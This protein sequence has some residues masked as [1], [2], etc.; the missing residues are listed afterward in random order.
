MSLVK[1]YYLLKRYK[2]ECYS[3]TLTAFTSL[4]FNRISEA[5]GSIT[6]AEA[7]ENIIALDFCG[8][9]MWLS[10]IILL[11]YGLILLLLER[12][13][14][15]RKLS[16]SFFEIMKCYVGESIRDSLSNGVLAWGEGKTV[17]YADN[18]ING[19]KSKNIICFYNDV[20]YTFLK[21][22]DREKRYGQ[23]PYYFNN[24]DWEAFENTEAFKKV[25]LAGNNLER[26]MLVD[27]KTNFDKNNRKLL[28]N[29]QRTIWSQTSYV[30][31][32]FGKENGFEISG[33]AL[34]T[35]Y[36]Q[37]ITSGLNS[38]SYLPNS[39]CMHLVIVTRDNK[40][41][42]SRI[43]QNKKNDNPG[44]WAVTL[45]EQ[46]DK[47]DFT[48]EINIHSDFVLRWLRRAFKEEYRLDE[49]N[50]AD[51]VDENS[52]RILSV[53]FEADRYNFAMVCVVNIN[54]SFDIFNKKVGSIL[55]SDE[56]T[57]L[58]YI[59]FKDI[60]KILCSYNNLEFRK[61]WHPSSFLRLLMVYFH[62]EGFSRA[63]REIERYHKICKGDRC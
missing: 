62:Y 14:S 12:I 10:L 36:A 46:I 11:C 18:I 60:P 29:L 27:S 16:S 15:K 3:I 40:I 7:W 17:N 43:S 34:L 22:E 57:E 41:V 35:E 9:I 58:G 59:D 49:D 53:D 55:S 38:E 39:F 47:I 30:W 50:Y 32:R 2:N 24:E 63:E 26:F 48:D 42:K 6:D 33:N 1:L 8:C 45:G 25:K 52:C 4:I 56:A 61:Q 54:Y 21:P 44:T 23:K 31:A 28:L 5:G 19:W 37:G 51:I 20:Q 13:V